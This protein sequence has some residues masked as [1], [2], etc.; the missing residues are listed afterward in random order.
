[1]LTRLASTRDKQMTSGS[2]HF[3]PGKLPQACRVK[4]CANRWSQQIYDPAS[5]HKAILEPRVAVPPLPL[6]LRRRLLLLPPTTPT[7]TFQYY[8]YYCYYLCRR[9]RER[10]PAI[11]RVV[12][13]VLAVVVVNINQELPTIN[14]HQPPSTSSSP[15]SVIHPSLTRLTR[16]QAS[17]YGVAYAPR[18]FQGWFDA[19][20][21]SS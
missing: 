1:M 10:E 14:H 9:N 3:W 21:D 4:D 16:A 11:M 5:F 19:G 15:A 2:T 17:S 6:L 13:V 18:N 8:D 7:R 20:D 12:A